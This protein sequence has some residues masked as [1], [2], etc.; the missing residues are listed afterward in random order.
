[1]AFKQNIKYEIMTPSGWSPFSG[2][3]SV[4]RFNGLRIT[5][6]NLLEIECTPEHRF[7]TP[8]GWKLA[9]SLTK[10]NSIIS[11]NG[12]LK[13]QSIVPILESNTY[14]DVLDTAKH[15]YYSNGLISHNCEFLGSSATL[16]SASKLRSLTFSDPIVKTAVGVEIYVKPIGLTTTEDAFGKSTTLPAHTY[17]LIADVSHGVGM[18]NSAFSVIDVTAPPWIQVAKFWNNEISPSAYP[19]VIA[20]T[21][22]YY[23]NAY[24]L[25]ESNDIG[26]QVLNDLQI[27]LELENLLGTTLTKRGQRLTSGHTPKHRNGVKTTT[28]VKRIGCSSIKDLIE[29]DQLILHDYDTVSEFATFVRHLNSFQ[30]EEGCH[31]DLVM[32][33]VL[34][35]WLAAQTAFKEI[36]DTNIRDK[37][38]QARLAQ[39]AN[40]MQPDS[41]LISDGQT[42]FTDKI[43]REL[44]YLDYS[45]TTVQSSW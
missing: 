13:I 36:T 19:D 43:D 6:S 31:D 18:D 26:S 8:S 16:I 23:N 17:V 37:M 24:V 14:Y 3:Q 27:E 41:I 25:C 22:R 34:F 32:G 12:R 35:G 30:A 39:L 5:M 15:E 28:A 10:R 20:K 21:A 9:S 44:G 7:L 1:M 29:H 33:L 45:T 40:D 4:T 11:D 2:V 38:A 42:E